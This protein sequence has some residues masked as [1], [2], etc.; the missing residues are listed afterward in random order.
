MKVTRELERILP[1]L[2]STQTNKTQKENSVDFAK[3]LNE[4]FKIQEA[5]A[6]GIEMP[7]S[8]NRSISGLSSMESI[9]LG[10]IPGALLT[11]MEGTMDIF[12]AYTKS[13][14]TDKKSAWA[15]LDNVSVNLN[16]LRKSNPDLAV[17][18][19]EMDTMLNEMEVLATTEKFKFNRGDYI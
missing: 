2:Q 3:V 16:S 15:E 13:L 1:E 5:S 18:N 4:Q 14:I 8:S 19:P 7:T 9:A 12:T 6:K 17:R 10:D 11:S